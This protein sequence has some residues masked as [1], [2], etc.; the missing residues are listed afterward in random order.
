MKGKALR[1]FIWLDTVV[2]DVKEYSVFDIWFLKI[3]L[4]ELFPFAENLFS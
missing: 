4:T 2:S 3:R 1:E